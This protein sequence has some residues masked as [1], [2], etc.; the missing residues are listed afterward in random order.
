[1]TTSWR[2]FPSSHDIKIINGIGIVNSS[3]ATIYVL[4][5]PTLLLQGLEIKGSW[6]ICD[7][8]LGRHS[9]PSAKDV[10][11]L[12]KE[13][14]KTGYLFGHRSYSMSQ[15]FDVIPKSNN[16][17]SILLFE[18]CESIVILGYFERKGIV[19]GLSLDGSYKSTST[20]VEICHFSRHSQVVRTT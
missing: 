13:L 16:L 1:M 4:I 8:D 3:S 12:R 14:C 2:R 5:E 19:A 6:G 9:E 7:R 20:L 11:V 10:F 18:G 15:G 17:L